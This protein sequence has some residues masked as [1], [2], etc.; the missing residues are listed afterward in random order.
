MSAAR[1]MIGAGRERCGKQ[2]IK[3]SR[4][5]G[6]SNTAEPFFIGRSQHMP[7]EELM[8]DR[9]VLGLLDDP[10]MTVQDLRPCKI[11]APLQPSTNSPPG[12][13]STPHELVA[14]LA[15]QRVQVLTDHD[16]AITACLDCV[17]V[18]LSL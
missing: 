1:A 8:Q 12:D 9:R 5:S 10:G 6:A 4:A 11:L 3:R 17:A 2:R 14:D 16:H 7:V 18:C 15:G 13:V